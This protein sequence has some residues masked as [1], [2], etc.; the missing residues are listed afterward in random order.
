MKPVHGTMS[1]IV[2]CGADS[3]TA[4]AAG[5]GV[6][7][8]RASCLSLQS[9]TCRP[10]LEHLPDS[11]HPQSLHVDLRDYPLHCL[12]QSKQQTEAAIDHQRADGGSHLAPRKHE[13]H[14]EARLR[15][16]CEG[17]PEA[18]PLWPR[19][20]PHSS[21]ITSSSAVSTWQSCCV[22]R[23][24]P[25]RLILTGAAMHHRRGF[26]E[27]DKRKRG[28]RGKCSGGVRCSDDVC[29]AV[30]TGHR[31]HYKVCA[32]RNLCRGPSSRQVRY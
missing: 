13:P 24:T 16:S 18:G 9:P 22:H 4:K 32:R 30:V 3:T 5:C 12:P 23:H 1:A 27:T 31:H 29:K 8:L 25:W 14:A 7:D 20:G 11:R 19:A 26:E 21:D 17:C 10:Q 6:L 15:L 2:C 28:R